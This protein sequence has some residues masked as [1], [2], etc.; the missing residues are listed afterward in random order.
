MNRDTG[1]K[2]ELD[3]LLSKY[4]ARR[5][6]A[7]VLPYMKGRRRI[8]DVGCGVFRWDGLLRPDAEY[9]GIDCEEE[10]VAYNRAHFP[11]T[12]FQADLDESRLDFC[13]S[14]FD[15]VVMLAILEHLCRPAQALVKLAQL[16]APGGL[17]VLTTPHASGEPILEAGAAVRL[18]SRDKHQHQPLLDKAG[19][20]ALV[21]QAGCELAAYRRFLLGFNQLVVVKRATDNGHQ[22]RQ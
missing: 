3:G 19:I 14:D 10:I 9:V 22:T 18:F 15:V 16:L 6:V 20:Q 13:G 11:H 8:L 5:R 4:L 1:I 12:F 7:A 21:A 2:G 17:I